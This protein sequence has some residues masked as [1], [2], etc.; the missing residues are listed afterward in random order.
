VRGRKETWRLRSATA[1]R[2]SS[3]ATCAISRSSQ[4]GKGIDIVFNLAA[5]RITQSVEEPRLELEVLVDGTFRLLEAAVTAKVAKV[6]A[7]SSAS[8]YGM[9][10]RLPTAENHHP[11]Q[12]SHHLRGGEG[13]HRRTAAQLQ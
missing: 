2:R 7:S 9:A 11:V 13:V 6:I 1:G 5:I 12:Q 3:A 10:D 4:G 8:V